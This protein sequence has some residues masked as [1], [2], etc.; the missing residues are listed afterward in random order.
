MTSADTTSRRW[1][2]TVAASVGALLLAGAQAA[3][4]QPGG[5]PLELPEVRNFVAGG[6]ALVP[7]YTGS[8]DYTTGIGPV[9]LLRFD[10]SERHVR[11]LATE[12]SVNLLDSPR[13]SLGP[14]LNYRFGRS[15][16]V[17][18]PVVSRMREIDGTVEAGGFVGWR[19]TSAADPR[20]QFRVQLQGQFDVAGEHGGHLVS[21]S[22]RYFA[23][24]AR[25][26]TLSLGGGATWAS[27]SFMQTYFGVD[28]ADAARSGLP[29]FA[30][31]GGT[32][33]VRISPTAIV[34]MSK[35]W[36]LSGGVILSRLVGDAED[37]PVVA[38]RGDSVQWMAG[39][40]LVYA[41]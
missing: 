28:P 22:T 12:L 24:V 16:G 30:A 17:A 33:D 39:L 20:H 1:W 9:G 29:V 41:W 26:L 36:H 31:G 13:F 11:L 10:A 37:S 32:R 40:G 6:I 23:P 5:F 35:N 25:W 38:A 21:L 27:D 15:D 14:L 2:R 8:D 4:Q 34:S 3:A 19:W 18:D 7:D